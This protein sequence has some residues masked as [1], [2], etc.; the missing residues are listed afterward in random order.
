VS[1]DPIGFA[2]GTN[3]YAYVDNDPVGFTDPSGL[4]KNKGWDQRAARIWFEIA[5]IRSAQ[6]FWKQAAQDQVSD[7]NWVGATCSDIFGGL[8]SLAEL[9]EVQ[10][11]GEIL[12]SDASAGRK[13]LAGA[14][15][16]RI[17]ASWYYVLTGDEIVP[18]DPKECRIA[19]GGNRNWRPGYKAPEINQLP[20]YHRRIPG[21][22]GKTVPGG[23]IKWHRPWEKGF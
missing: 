14:D 12:G 18:S 15:L 20:H 2:G 21:P 19:P 9:D 23:S 5:D 16:V 8:I 22:N 11:D 17:G 1:E 3:F 6:A 10:K 13:I 4:E 7:G